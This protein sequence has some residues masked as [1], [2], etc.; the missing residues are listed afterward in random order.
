M[1]TSANRV[2]V[3]REPFMGDQIDV[4]I[5]QRAT[6][7]LPC[8]AEPVI[9]REIPPEELP[10]RREP[11]F[12]LTPEAAQS[13]MDELWRC[14]LR[15]TEGSGSAGSLAATERHLADMRALVFKTTPAA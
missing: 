4:L 14:G 3:Q 15:P 7:S 13:L 1:R 2:H 9:F 10:T 6:G 11:T 5:S 8:Y 12:S